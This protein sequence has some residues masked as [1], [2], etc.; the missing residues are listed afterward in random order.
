M[1]GMMMSATSEVTTAPSALPMI[2]PMASARAFVLVR[3]AM[4]SLNIGRLPPSDSA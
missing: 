2:T 1:G 4:N 3:N